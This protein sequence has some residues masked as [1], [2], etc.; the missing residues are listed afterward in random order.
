MKYTRIKSNGMT[1]HMLFL[2]VFLVAVVALILGAAVSDGR[3]ATIQLDA[4]EI[5]IEI[6]WTDGDAGIHMFL[7]GEGWDRMEVSDP[8]GNTN[9]DVMA[10]ADNSVGQ[11]GITEL[12][13]ESAEPSFEEQPLADLLALFPE[14]QYRFEG[15]TT[16]GDILRGTGRLTHN[17]PCAP[18]DVVATEH[19]DG[20]L[21]IEWDLVTRKLNT[22]AVP[23]VCGGDPINIAGIEVV[24]EFEQQGTGQTFVVSTE[25]GPSAES[26]TVASDF[27]DSLAGMQGELKAEVIAREVS[28]NQTITEVEFEEEEEE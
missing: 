15:E 18:T 3:A 28:G 2:P 16:E 13:F 27:L 26:L 4:S 22:A 6:N 11:Q 7:D 20:S 23:V 24:V 10:D 19:N 25:L 8:D 14:G 12:F 9:V 5:Y 1:K 21:T 17:L